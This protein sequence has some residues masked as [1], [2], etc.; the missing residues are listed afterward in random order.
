MEI[1]SPTLSDESQE[2]KDEDEVDVEAMYE[3]VYAKSGKGLGKLYF[4]E[5]L[6]QMDP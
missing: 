3:E 1:L 2:D 6:V 4:D 5:P